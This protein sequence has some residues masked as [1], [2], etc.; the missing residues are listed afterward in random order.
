LC[1]QLCQPCHGRDGLRASIVLW[2]TLWRVF[3]DFYTIGRF[4]DIVKLKRQDVVYQSSQ[5]PHLKIIFKRGKNDQY[6]EGSERVVAAN[7]ISQTCPVQLNLNHFQFLGLGYTGYLVPACTPKNEPNSVKAVPY[8]EVLG[9][10]GNIRFKLE[11]GQ[12]PTRS[13]YTSNLPDTAIS[14]RFRNLLRCKQLAPASQ[15]SDNCSSHIR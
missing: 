1:A 15:P 14:I 12:T 2:R 13:R 8:S 7:P 6:S 3:L 4:S 11:A 9:D 5:S 10:N